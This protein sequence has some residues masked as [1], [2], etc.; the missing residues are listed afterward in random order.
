MITSKNN[1]IH[2]LSATYA[3]A[4]HDMKIIHLE[5]WIFPPRT[6]IFQDS[7]FQSH[8]PENT[9]VLQ[10]IKR[11]KGKKLTIRQKYHNWRISQQ[12]VVVEHAIRGVKIFR[13]VKDVIRNW[14]EN[15][16]DFVFEICC[17][18]HNF[19]IISN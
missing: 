9:L 1:Y 19:K 16:K 3:G 8:S 17:G 14:K 18:L 13:I 7:G 6:I 15:F 11:K 5:E 2:F 10:P 12:R 4:V